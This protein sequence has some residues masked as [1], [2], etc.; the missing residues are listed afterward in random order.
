[1]G[2]EDILK[3]EPVPYYFFCGHNLTGSLKE[4]IELLKTKK[5]NES[6]L[7][8]LLLAPGQQQHKHP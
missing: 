8:W 5:Q 2:L 4:S 1:M 6:T 3:L 7:L